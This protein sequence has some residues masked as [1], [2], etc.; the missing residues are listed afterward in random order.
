MPARYAGIGLPVFLSLI[1]TCGV[2]LISTLHGVGLNE[3][4]LYLW[5]GAWGLSWAVAFPLLLVM[6]PLARAVT[7]WVVERP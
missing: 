2:S 1:M 4:F 7:G 5:L 3:H 6:L